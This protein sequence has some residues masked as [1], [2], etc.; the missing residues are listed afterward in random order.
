[1]V[2]QIEHIFFFS[3]GVSRETAIY[4]KQLQRCLLDFTLATLN[5]TGIREILITGNEWSRVS[6]SYKYLQIQEYF[7]KV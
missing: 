3:N 1:M 2:L 7:M 5:T 4:N 6:V